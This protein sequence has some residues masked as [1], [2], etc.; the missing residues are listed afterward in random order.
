MSYVL[1]TGCFDILHSGHVDLINFA[2]NKFPNHKIIVAIDSDS[3]VKNSKG[4]HRPINNDIDRHSVISSIKNVHRA[5]IFDRDSDLYHL[6][7]FLRPIRIL[8]ED[9][10]GKPIIGKKYCQAI[11]YLKRNQHS[12]TETIRKINETSSVIR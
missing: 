9:Y 7:E 12:T 5:L 1:I 10:K 11:V 3:R 4:S 8:G 2:A 6:C